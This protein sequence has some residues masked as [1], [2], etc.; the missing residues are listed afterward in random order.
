MWSEG[1]HR[2]VLIL[3]PPERRSMSYAACD[4]PWA[5]F[6]E[7]QRDPQFVVASS[8]PGCTWEGPSCVPRPA[9]THAKPRGRSTKVT[10][11]ICLCLPAVQPTPDSACLYIGRSLTTASRLL[12]RVQDWQGGD[13]G[14]QEGG[15]SGPP[16]KV[17]CYWSGAQ[18][19][20][21]APFPEPQN[22]AS[23]HTI[24]DTP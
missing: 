16:V 23:P 19:R 15:A 1:F 14:S 18:G 21:M 5:T 20:K 13:P 7:L 3:G 24:S 9:A 8:K 11:Q 17:V 6:L 2:T 22:T 12:C 10:R 4:Q